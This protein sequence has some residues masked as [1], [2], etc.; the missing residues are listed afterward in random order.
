[1]RYDVRFQLQ[2]G[3]KNINSV[4]Y[5]SDTAPCTKKEALAC[6][7]GLWDKE[8]DYFRDDEWR[9]EYKAAIEKAERAVKNAR[10]A[11]AGA[12]RN[13]C[14]ESFRHKDETYRVDIAIEAGEGHFSD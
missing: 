9:R 1:M 13:F 14:S 4:S 8:K 10:N 5:H 12:N 2:A 11:S 3:S 7:S 6:L